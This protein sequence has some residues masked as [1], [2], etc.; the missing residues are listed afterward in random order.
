[1][2]FLFSYLTMPAKVTV[3][4]AAEE[5]YSIAGLG[6]LDKAS[7]TYN[8]CKS[9]IS[10]IIYKHLDLDR[11]KAEDGCFSRVIPEGLGIEIA[12]VIEAEYQAYLDQLPF[13]ELINDV[14]ISTLQRIESFAWRNGIGILPEAIKQMVRNLV[15]TADQYSRMQERVDDS[16][17][18]KSF[19]DA[20]KC[21]LMES[22][23]GTNDNDVL[24]YRQDMIEYLEKRLANLMYS[25]FERFFNVASCS[26]VFNDMEARFESIIEY[27]KGQQIDSESITDLIIPDDFLNGKHQVFTTSEA[28]TPEEIISSAAISITK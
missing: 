11:F 21:T 5:L 27:I 26:S 24:I 7:N 22:I 17:L 23:A 13:L 4:Q 20:S 15:K 28:R 2:E 19:K 6:P 12:G 14:E 18:M 1:M 16:S 25:F 9:Q 3:N 8:E 10:A